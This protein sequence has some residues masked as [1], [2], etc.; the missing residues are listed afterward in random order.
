[1]ELF[2]K[3]NLLAFDAAIASELLEAIRG[4]EHL[5]TVEKCQADVVRVEGGLS[6]SL[7]EQWLMGLPLGVTFATYHIAKLLCEAI[8]VDVGDL[9]GEQMS[10]LDEYYWRTM[11]RI[12]ALI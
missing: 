7:A 12:L 10:D 11:G 5:D 4:S 1:M 3:T 8:S 2:T 9:S 6:P